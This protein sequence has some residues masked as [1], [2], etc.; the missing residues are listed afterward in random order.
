MTVLQAEIKT[1]KPE[2]LPLYVEVGVCHCE[3]ENAFI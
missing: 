2:V 3:Q 1:S